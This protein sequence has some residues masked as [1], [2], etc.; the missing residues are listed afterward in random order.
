MIRIEKL[1]FIPFCCYSC[2]CCCFLQIQFFFSN[3]CRRPMSYIIFTHS[4]KLQSASSPSLSLSSRTA[5]RTHKQK[6]GLQISHTK[7]RNPTDYHHHC[8]AQTQHISIVKQTKGKE[9]FF[10]FLGGAMSYSSLLET[11]RPT[12]KSNGHS[13]RE[14]ARRRACGICIRCLLAVVQPRDFPLTLSLTHSLAH[15]RTI[16]ITIYSPRMDLS[17]TRT[18]RHKRKSACF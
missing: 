18:H 13:T 16:I 11:G 2:C 4:I 15:T 6:T 17:R 12:L 10:F 3:T 7:F 9:Y 8:R 5:T 14:E 1:S